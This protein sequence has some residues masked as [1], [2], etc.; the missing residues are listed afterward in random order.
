[1]LLRNK[2]RRGS[3][4]ANR[5][6]ILGLAFALRCLPWGQSSAALGQETA[7]RIDTVYSLASYQ[8]DYSVVGTYG[9]NA[10]RLIGTY[11]ADGNGNVSGSARVNLPGPDGPRVVV[12]I[13]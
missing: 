12:S 6:M 3:M 11:R 13:S 4:L 5:R 7:N 2:K 8:G 9:A 1:M 10:A